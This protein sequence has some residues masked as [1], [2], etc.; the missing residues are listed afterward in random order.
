MDD[1]D[2][3]SET[4][5]TLRALG[6][7]LAGASTCELE[8]Y[9]GG[10]SARQ[11]WHN[12]DPGRG[13]VDDHRTRTIVATDVVDVDEFLA[14]RSAGSWCPLCRPVRSN[15]AAYDITAVSDEEA[16]YPIGQILTS[17]FHPA[18]A[19]TGTRY[20][21]MSATRFSHQVE[22]QWAAATLTDV[23]TLKAV[24]AFH[25]V[26]G[27]Q[28]HPQVYQAVL[29]MLPSWKQALDAYLTSDAWALVQANTVAAL[30][31]PTIGDN[32]ALTRLP[33]RWRSERSA[34]FD[35]VRADLA[36]QW[37]GPSVWVTCPVRFDVPASKLG[38]A[39]AVNQYAAAALAL[40]T[41]LVPVTE[42]V[43]KLPP[44]DLHARVG[45]TV[46]AFRIPAVLKDALVPPSHTFYRGRTTLC[47]GDGVNAA[48]LL[49]AAATFDGECPFGEYVTLVGAANR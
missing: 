32:N 47:T 1:I 26:L 18:T 42:P 14:L 20:I 34:F 16:L 45:G 27:E 5:E 8:E 43:R 29:R 23:A 25:P 40:E 3:F 24:L 7:P 13:C 44:V 39:Y 15:L 17:P 41:A 11:V 35:T 28:L 36:D 21:G 2:P 4:L 31:P 37:S 19:N 22:Q 6:I 30:R 49:A 10:R 9:P 33:D 46:A 12:T 48:D 38:Q